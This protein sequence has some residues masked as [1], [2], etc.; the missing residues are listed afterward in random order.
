MTSNLGIVKAIQTELKSLGL[1][2]PDELLT[3]PEV[4]TIPE[5]TQNEFLDAVHAASGDPAADETVQLL[6]NRMALVRFGHVN[7]AMKT[8]AER[9]QESLILAYA[10]EL[11]AELQQ[12]HAREVDTLAEALRTIPSNQHIKDIRLEGLTPRQHETAVKALTAQ[13]RAERIRAV[14]GRIHALGEWHMDPNRE[15]YRSRLYL[16]ANPTV[17]QFAEA[18]DPSPTRFPQHEDEWGILQHGW[19]VKLADSEEH[20]RKRLKMLTDSTAP[21]GNIE[22]DEARVF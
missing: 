7:A 14:W 4:P 18:L 21:T 13:H 2:W 19:E 1:S 11:V 15:G 9:K 3:T 16:L 6:V 5:P 8:D 10:D 12:L 17:E 20:A 22:N